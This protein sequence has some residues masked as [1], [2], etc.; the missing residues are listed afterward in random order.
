MS[1]RPKEC[2]KVILTS[3]FCNTKLYTKVLNKIA[4]SADKPIP[5]TLSPYGHPHHSSFS[6][7][8]ALVGVLPR[9]SQPIHR[10]IESV[11]RIQLLAAIGAIR[12]AAFSLF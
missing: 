8:R 2:K 3:E 11:S 10:K 12:A 6:R 5:A 4:I 7:T 1:N 9:I